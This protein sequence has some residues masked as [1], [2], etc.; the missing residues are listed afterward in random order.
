MARQERET[1]TYSSWLPYLIDS[2]RWIRQ[3]W[4]ISEKERIPPKSKLL[5]PLSIVCPTLRVT[6][7]RIVDGGITPPYPYIVS[8][9]VFSSEPNYTVT[10]DPAASFAAE[11]ERPVPPEIPS[12][13][14]SPPGKVDPSS[15]EMIPPTPPSPYIEE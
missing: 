9:S 1:Q 14:T 8:S 5:A 2:A 10:S 6:Y 13:P 4:H 12:P 7:E 15:S 11:M 3:G